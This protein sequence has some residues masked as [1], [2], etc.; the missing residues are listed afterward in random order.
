MHSDSA[1]KKSRHP[2][3]HGA[4]VAFLIASILAPA[5]RAQLGVTDFSLIDGVGAG[6][7]GSAIARGDFDADGFDDLV[8]GAPETE[9]AALARVGAVRVH[10][11][12]SQGW[13]RI[14]TLTP[15]DLGD[16][17]EAGAQF[18]AALA[19]GDFDDDGFD[20]LAIGMPGRMVNFG[21]RAG[22]VFVTYGGEDPFVRIQFVS[23][24]LFEGI[25]EDNDRFGTSLAAGDLSGDGVDDLVIGV[26]FEDVPDNPGP[27]G[28]AEDAGAVNIVS[29]AAAIALQVA[30]NQWLHQDSPGV[31]LSANA[32]ELFGF[33]LAIGQFEDDPIPDLAVGTPGEVVSGPGQKGAVVVFAG[34]VDGLDP[35]ANSERVW[36]QDDPAILGSGQDGDQFG[37]ALA[38]GDFNGDSW[39]DLAIGAPGESQFGV[40][41]AG[42]V[43]ALY[44]NFFGLSSVDQLFLESSFDPDV[45]PFDRLGEALAAGDFDGDRRDDLAIG[46]PLDNSLGFTNAGEVDV[47]YGTPEGLTLVGGQVFNMIF[48]GALEIADEFGAALAAGR[49]FSASAEA[50]DLAIGIPRRGEPFGA[51]PGA[52]VVVRS[53]SIFIDGFESG[54]TSRWAVTV[55]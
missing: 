11:G 12:G 45:D 17:A 38:V 4:S 33:S 19:T 24:L 3:A 36:S 54:D 42:A 8:M 13:S 30:G 28:A 32:N 41:E 14:E 7:L 50:Q 2:L 21:A 53:R 40:E 44:G 9:V 37:Y 51:E 49:F 52:V 18:G 48:F 47:L 31:T 46:A 43:H 34:A 1:S 55:P 16:E 23:Q 10:Y 20:D 27:L 22:G 35:V 25:P 29:G 39:T 26:P 15:V 6:S 5:A